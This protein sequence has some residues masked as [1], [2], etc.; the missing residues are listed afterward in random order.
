MVMVLTSEPCIYQLGMHSQRVKDAETVRREHYG[1]AFSQPCWLL[2]V[3]CAFDATL[4]QAEREGQTL[5]FG[6]LSYVVRSTTILTEMPA[7]MMA[8]SNADCVAIAV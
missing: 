6:Q 5:C 8:T 7:P 2:I 3:D 1:V 4:T